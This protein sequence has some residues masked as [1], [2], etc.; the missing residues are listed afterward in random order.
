LALLADT[1]TVTLPDKQRQKIRWYQP[2]AL[3][4]VLPIPVHLPALAACF[5]KYFSGDVYR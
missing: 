2:V 5:S 4:P 3:E 1:T